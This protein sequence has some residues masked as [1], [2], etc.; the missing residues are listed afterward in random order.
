VLSGEWG[1]T[2]A[3]FPGCTYG[4]RVSRPTQGK[5]VPRMW[6][7]ALLGGATVGICYDW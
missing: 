2:S 3:A 5:Y 7:A 4:N 6:F 1:Y